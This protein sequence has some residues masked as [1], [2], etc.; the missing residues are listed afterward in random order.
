[1]RCLAALA[2]WEELNNLCKEYWSPAEPSARLEMAP[3]AAQAAWNMGEWDQMAEYVS[4][5]DD[6]DETKLRGLA[7]PVSSGDGSSNGTFFRAVLLV[8]RAKYDEARE[9]VE[10]ARKCLAT[11]LAALVLESYERAYSNMVRVQQLSELEEVIEYYTLPVGNTI[12]EERRAL[13]RNMWTQRIQGS[14]RNVE[15]WQALLA[16]R[17]L[18]LPPTEDVET[19]LKFASL[20][21][22]S[23]RI[24]QAKS[25]LLKL[26]PFDPEVSPENMQYHGPPQVMLGYLKYQWSLGEERKRK[27]A[28]TKLQILTR[29]LSSV[30]HSQSDILA[31]MVSSKGANVPLLA[32]V[33]L[34]LGTWQWALSSGL[35]DGSIQEIRDAFDKS[36]CY[37]PKWAKAWHTWALFNT[38]V[39]SHYISRGQIASQYV[40]S[41]V[42]GYFYSIA[43]AANAKGVD[44]SLQDILR[45]LTLWFNHGATADVQTALKTGFSH[46]NINTWL[47]VLPQIIA[48]IHS[49]NR[50]VRELIQSLLIRIGENHPQ[51]LM[52]PLLVACKSIS[53]LRRA[54]AQE[55]VDKVRQHSGALVDQVKS[56]LLCLSILL[57]YIFLPELISDPLPLHP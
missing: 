24:S 47:V 46:V 21:R 11:E 17:A 15:V 2:R 4:R 36:T 3:M 25:T 48:R 31:S 1:M 22:K 33:N 16:V 44:D 51:A 53:N 13:I 20:C 50:A 8:R 14:K 26:L 23:G 32:R 56:H 39:M 42:T 49:N 57:N 52:Y 28:F 29:E 34:K 19:W 55:V 54:A 5:L 30:P 38:A 18:V 10:R 12:A 27:E 43:C 35:N 41:A 40:V 45:L 37:A 7:S 9:Y 6:G